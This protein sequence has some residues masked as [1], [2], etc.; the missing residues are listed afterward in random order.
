M[1]EYG[2]DISYKQVHLIL[3]LLLLKTIHSHHAPG[4]VSWAV[5][6]AAERWALTSSPQQ[7]I[8]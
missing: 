8:K 3:D 2:Q 5:A 7:I 4:T 1:S 6:T